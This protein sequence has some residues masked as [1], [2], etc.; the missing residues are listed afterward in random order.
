MSLPT[1]SVRLVDAL[2]HAAEL[3]ALL[4]SAAVVL[5]LFPLLEG[6]RLALD[7]LFASDQ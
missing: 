1:A 6:L 5:A 7:A 2:Q 3:A 4:L